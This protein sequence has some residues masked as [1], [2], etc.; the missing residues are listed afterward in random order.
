MLIIINADDLGLSSA[1]N[2]AIFDLM[3]RGHVTS[4]SLLANAPATEEAIVESRHQKDRSFGVHLN[5]TEFRPL[6]RSS[7]LSPILDNSGCFAG[8][9]IRS[10]PITSQLRDAIFQEW[11]A[12]IERLLAMGVTPSHIDSHHH[13][14]TIPG[15]FFVLKRVQRR[16]GV[17]KV[18]ISKNIY[19]TKAQAPRSLLLRKMLWNAAVRWYYPTITTNGFTSLNDFLDAAHHQQIR[20]RSVEIMVHP[21]GSGEYREESELLVKSWRDRLPFQSTLINFSSLTD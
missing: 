14:H 4:S 6:T 20:Y 17:R 16:F 8:D 9:S 3:E 7:A 19:P 15:L 1:V 2:E 12:Q 18:R 13:V 5:L 10:T 21:G 11:S